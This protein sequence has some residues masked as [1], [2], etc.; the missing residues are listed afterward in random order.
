MDE[1]NGRGL[2][3]LALSDIGKGEN[4]HIVIGGTQD[5]TRSSADKLRKRVDGCRYTLVLQDAEALR[6]MGVRDRFPIKKELPPG[7]GFMV[8][9]VQASLTQICL[10]VLD[11]LDGSSPDEQLGEL[12]SA[13]KKKYRKSAQWSYK[14]SDMSALNTAVSALT[15][16]SETGTSTTSYSP[17]AEASG[18]M[19]DLEKLLA[20]QASAKSKGEK[21]ASAP[22]KK[23][24]R[25]RKTSKSSTT[26]RKT[27]TKK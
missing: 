15:G 22:K 26:Q 12:I 7:R 11:G 24:T 17:S 18:A 1:L 4:L 10:P 5:I 2:G 23:T 21:E 6:Y 27:T 16:S 14:A 20:E 19:A 13:I 25:S 3:T 8:K 9:A